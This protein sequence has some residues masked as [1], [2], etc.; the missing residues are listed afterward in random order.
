MRRFGGSPA[1]T[2][3]RAVTF[4]VLLLVTVVMLY[5]FWFMASSAFR[6]LQQYT[7]GLPGLSLASWRLLLQ[8]LPIG[9]QVLNS[10]IVTFGSIL[11][12]LILSAMGGYAFSKLSYRGSQLIFLAI[13]ASMMIPVQSMIIPEYTNLSYVGLINQYIGAILVYTALY[14]PF[15]TFLMTMYFRGIPNDLIE[16]AVVDGLGYLRIFFRV[17]LPMAIPAL[18]TIVVL[19]FIQIWDDFLVGLLFLQGPDVRTITVGLA[20]LNAARVLNVPVMMAGSLV[21][22]IPAIIVYLLFQ[23]YL[24]AGLT[25]GMGK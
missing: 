18:A 4:L 17:M 5:P 11:L 20:T 21:S 1:R 3:S 8:L 9:Q 23:R 19:E 7:L 14:T 16:A 25:M 12:I 24:I 10:S 13:L 2:I 6:S 15:A 22:A